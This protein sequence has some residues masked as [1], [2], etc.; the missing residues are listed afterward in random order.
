MTLIGFATIDGKRLA[1]TSDVVAAFVNGEC[2]GVQELLL[3]PETGNYHVYLTIH[4]DI[5]NEIVSFKVYDA[6]RNIIRDVLKT[7]SFKAG[8]NGNVANILQG[9][10]FSNT[11]LLSG[12]ELIS[13]NLKELTPI[14]V[15]DFDNKKITFNLATYEEINA[16]TINFSLSTGASLFKGITEISPSTILDFTDPIVFKVI[17]EDQSASETWTAKVIV[18]PPEA[19]YYKKDA[20]CYEGGFIKVLFPIEGKEVLLEKGA[21]SKT[22][23]ITDGQVIFDDLNEGTY[24]I[25]INAS[26]KNINIQL[27]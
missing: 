12:A 18:G 24:Q 17:S 23:I 25:R 10:S 19:I 7:E 21:A 8:G 6:T 3:I 26:S 20:L 15:I 27:K 14:P 16:L 11:V 9:F 22:K 13:M 2:R 5:E 4:G 1:T